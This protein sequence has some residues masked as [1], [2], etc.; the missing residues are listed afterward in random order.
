MEKTR[1]A[2][3]VFDTWAADSRAEEMG[4]HH[5][6][7]VRQAFEQVV[8]PAGDYLEIGVGNGYGLSYLA[9]HQ[10]R[11]R[12]CLGLDVSAN[13]V[14]LAQ[15]ATH[16]LANV[17]V[18]QADF[19]T[20]FSFAKATEKFSL[21]FSMEVFYYF[22]DMQK[23]IDKAASLLR[24]GGQLWVLVDYYRENRATHDW[25]QKLATPMQLWS[26]A[27]YRAGFERAG[28]VDVRQR[29]LQDPAKDAKEAGMLGT[30]WTQG[31]SG[32]GGKNQD[33]D[34]R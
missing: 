24:P 27:E 20:C 10:F 21:I 16:D 33:R 13:M 12:R 32:S 30:L 28:L 18:E 23:G 11:K 14:A 2:A 31:V 19:L 5:W 34:N 4:A 7:V 26:M 25:P 9:R 17:Q 1:T 15:E 22:V 3:E 6:P 29:Q 8:E